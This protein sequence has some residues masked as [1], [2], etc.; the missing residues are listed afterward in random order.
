MIGVKKS[1]F[2]VISFLTVLCIIILP[3]GT[4]SAESNFSGNPVIFIPGFMQSHL[5]LEENGVCREI[6]PVHLKERD[7]VKQLF[8]KGV[9]SFSL[10]SDRGL[11]E[12]GSAVAAALLDK[13]TLDENGAM[14]YNV[15]PVTY[16][17]PLSECNEYERESILKMLP[18][19]RV[20][21]DIPE[22]Q[23]YLFAYNWLLDPLETAEELHKFINKVCDETGKDCVQLASYSM[24]G[25][26]T[27]AYFSRFAAEKRVSRVVYIAA[28]MQGSKVFG[29]L[30]SGNV[31]LTTDEVRFV[32]LP[33]LFKEKT[34]K[35]IDKYIKYIPEDA[36]SNFTSLVCE[37]LMNIIGSR[38]AGVW[39]IVPAEDYPRLRSMHLNSAE[40]ENLRRKTDA[41][42]DVQRN[43]PELLKSVKENGTELLAIC[44]YGEALILPE[45]ENRASSD[46]L[47]TVYSASGGAY[48]SPLGKTLGEG[49]VEK[50][51]YCTDETH[52]HISPDKTL[53]A[54]CGLFPEQ[55]WYF[56]SQSHTDLKSNDKIGSL[57]SL[58]LSY[59]GCTDIYSDER[60]PQFS[61]YRDTAELQRLIS[62][63]KKEMPDMKESERIIF[64]EAVRDCERLLNSANINETEFNDSAL[65]LARLCKRYY[66]GF[67]RGTRWPFVML[68]AAGILG[69]LITVA[70]IRRKRIYELSDY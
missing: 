5:K 24:G 50:R 11:A 42:Y 48:S 18:I 16:D 1:F 2:R 19:E 26:I 34:V 56:K 38:S 41:F 8:W 15:S 64:E 39:A 25:T 36:I 51:T 46:R 9:E 52:R 70:G 54:S 68:G 3:F 69:I 49:Y 10:Q 20:A 62:A 33:T 66:V 55:T 53:D 45:D 23:I 60:F 12:R 31:D 22:S 40:N 58:I 47:L 57:L 7:V 14:I 17:K 63:A 13:L 65:K 21:Q 59:N 4:A 30:M 61:D 37:E 27:N 32:V 43:L 67:E 44:G 35:R 29:D 28:S 6:W